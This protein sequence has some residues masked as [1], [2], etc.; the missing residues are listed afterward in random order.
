VVQQTDRGTADGREDAVQ[1]NA[2]H[3][4]RGVSGA[5]ETT[6]ALVA[7]RGRLLELREVDLNVLD[8]LAELAE[9]ALARS[10]Q[11]HL[12]VFAAVVDASVQVQGHAAGGGN[13]GSGGA[14]RRAHVCEVSRRREMS[15]ARYSG[16]SLSG[17]RAVSKAH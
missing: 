11:T 10:A 15:H 12:S 1:A 8:G 16:A 2:D 9:S 7:P 13:E 3:G 4:L 6:A 5:N 17:S 14:D